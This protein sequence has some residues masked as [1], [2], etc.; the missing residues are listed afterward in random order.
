MFRF[1][2]PA[3]LRTLALRS[4]ITVQVGRIAATNARSANTAAIALVIWAAYFGPRQGDA[5]TLAITGPQGE[6]I[7]QTIAIDRTQAIA[8]R[9]VGKRT[10]Q[11][12][13]PAGNADPARRGL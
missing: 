11:G 4:D 13:W 10:P 7:R 8:F 1:V 3:S 5:L 2:D 6:V 12:G 9:A